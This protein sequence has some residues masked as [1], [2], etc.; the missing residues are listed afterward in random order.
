MKKYFL[1]ALS[2]ICMIFGSQKIYSQISSNYLW[3]EKGQK[4][5]SVELVFDIPQGLSEG[6][7]SYDLSLNGS[8]GINIIN[9][10]GI[11]MGVGLI[12]NSLHTESTLK[13]HSEYIKTTKEW[14]RWTTGEEASSNTSFAFQ[15]MPGIRY[16]I[17]DINLK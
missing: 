8:K 14:F 3:T 6:Y 7:S 12:M 15:L 11:E 4:Y 9:N 1:G 17:N 2:L 13:N 5:T 10:L 16:S